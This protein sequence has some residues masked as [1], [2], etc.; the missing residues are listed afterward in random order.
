[1]HEWQDLEAFRAADGRR[2]GPLAVEFGSLWMASVTDEPW[3]VEW[4]EATGEL[5]AVQR[6]P[7]GEPDGPVRLLGRHPDRAEVERTLRGWWQV[8]GH[9]GSLPWIEH[10]GAELLVTGEPSD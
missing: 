10:R 1:M 2:C 5:V 7:V 3:R 8:C 9:R 6:G 4:L